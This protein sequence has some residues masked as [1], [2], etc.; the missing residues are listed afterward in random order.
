MVKAGKTTQS[1]TKAADS[2]DAAGTIS[3]GPSAASS[4]GADDIV[5]QVHAALQTAPESKQSASTQI[6]TLTPLWQLNFNTAKLAEWDVMVH[7]ARLEEYEYPWEGKQ[8]KAK[9]FKCVLVYV[10]DHQQYCIAELRKE[11]TSPPTWAKDASDKF[12]DGNKFRM[13]AV[14]LNMKAKVEYVSTTV[15]ITV[16]LHATKMTKLLADATPRIPQPTMTCLECSQYKSLQALDITALI[17]T[18]SES[19]TVSGQKRARDIHILDGTLKVAKPLNGD[20]PQKGDMVILKLCIFYDVGMHGGSQIGD[21]AWVTKLVESASQAMPFH[22]YGIQAK[23]TNEG[24][25]FETMRSWFKIVPATGPDNEK[26]AQ[27]TNDFD[28]IMEQKNNGN[29]LVLEK[30]WSAN[31]GENL[32]DVTGQ[33]TLC[34]HLDAM[35]QRT[36]V[37]GLD[38]CTTVWH[39]NWCFITILPGS[40]LTDN[41]DKLWLK[42]MCQDVSGRVEARM[43]EKVA[44]EVSGRDNKEDFLQAISDGDAI[45]PTIMSLKLSRRLKEVKSENEGG[46]PNVFVNITVLEAGAQDTSMSRTISVK[47]LV[48]VLRSLTTISTAILP[49]TRSML[50]SSAAYPMQVQYPMENLDPQPCQ[51]VWM[52]IKVSKKSKCTEEPPYTVTTED[53][54]DVLDQNPAIKDAS[55][56]RKY[57]LVTTCSKSARTSLILTPSHGKSV[58]AVAVI[59]AMQGNILCAESVEA[60]QLDDKTALST[61]MMQE[62]SLAVDL[63]THTSTG[64]ATPWSDAT[65]PLGGSSCRIL[66]KSPTGPPLDP[67]EP[68]VAKKARLS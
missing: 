25:H 15:K 4:R 38:T 19:R 26:G 23:R 47:Q 28:N 67:L 3:S 49:A 45:F 40:H 12:K 36:G 61:T 11:K 21:P 37:L 68:T 33:E 64:V 62:M 57:I 9:V 54:E 51:K 42:V 66:S 18:V 65:S 2:G 35:S 5:A 59:T 63:V 55:Q 60:V 52:L 17:D 46:D 14:E 58:F 10:D 27:L 48:P 32:Q 34:A 56:G 24:P 1:V 50:M 41:G 39:I 16:N 7:D 30:Q 29:V 53:V 44:L 13:S 6:K 43:G 8:K 20:E 22:F 31:G